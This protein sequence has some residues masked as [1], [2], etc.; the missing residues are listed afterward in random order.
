MALTRQQEDFCRREYPRLVQTLT[1]FCGDSDSA[2][3]LAHQALG[4]ACS[5]W[6][7][8][9][10]SNSPAAW[11]SRLGMK[12]GTRPFA[13]RRPAGPIKE[14]PV[15]PVIPGR[16]AEGAPAVRR[17]VLALPTRQRTALLLRHFIQLSAF[18]TA[19]LMDCDARAVRKLTRKAIDQLNRDPDVQKFAEAGDA[20]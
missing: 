11:V 16:R 8:V 10:K 9:Q 7:K 14:A 15:N 19:E 3:D 2:R 4:R 17:A 6:T 1:L 13:A 20:S 5:R 18:E 12:L